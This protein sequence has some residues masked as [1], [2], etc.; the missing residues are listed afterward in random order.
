MAA[1]ANYNLDADFPSLADRDNSTQ[2][3][4]VATSG[5]AAALLNGRGN[6]VSM[7]TN[8]QT[9]PPP[10]PPPPPPPASTATTATTTTTT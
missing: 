9:S 2:K 6:G 4:N 8:G 1:H 7:S 3:I 5:Y 10:P